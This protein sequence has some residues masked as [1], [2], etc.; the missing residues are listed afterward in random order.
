MIDIVVNTSN[1]PKEVPT[2]DSTNTPG[3]SEPVILAPGEGTTPTNIMR[4][5]HWEVRAWPCM[6]PTRRYSLHQYRDDPLTNIQYVGQ[7]L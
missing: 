3:I 6:F 7:R 5:K 2:I 1:A 4:E